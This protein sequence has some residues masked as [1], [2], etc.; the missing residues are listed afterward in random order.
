[1]Q[2][3][4]DVPSHSP[5]ATGKF[6]SVKVQLYGRFML[7]DRTEHACQIEEMSP[8]N[9]ILTTDVMAHNGER[10]IAYIDHIGRIEGTVE[11]AVR[12]G[13]LISLV[14]SDRKKNKIAAQ[15]TWL[16]NKH[17]LDMPEDRRHQRV[18]PRNPIST[19]SMADGRQ[20]PCRIIDLSISGAAVEIRI[21]PALNSEVV[22]GTM[23]GRVVRHFEEG[24]AIEFA[25]V[26]SRDTIG[27]ALE[28]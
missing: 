13:F 19:L 27:L 4:R 22:L 10:V 21:R 7:E 15:L 2:L 12:G 20:Y 11:R 1:M 28:H 14:A 23:R 8:G 9:A 16:T 26:Q 3:H 17:E 18:A 6:F 5:A 25:T 24:I